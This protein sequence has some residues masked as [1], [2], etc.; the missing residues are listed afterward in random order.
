MTCV[1]DVWLGEAISCSA[2]DSLHSQMYV[3]SVRAP[4]LARACVP[5]FQGKGAID[6]GDICGVRRDEILAMTS[7]VGLRQPA[8]CCSVSVLPLSL[9][10]TAK[11]S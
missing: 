1:V 10:L 7:D 8:S 2:R 4:Q 3:V 9:S 6:L 5:L 11:P